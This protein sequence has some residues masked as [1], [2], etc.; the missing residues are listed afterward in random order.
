MVIA[1]AGFQHETNT[2]APSKADYR[3][4]AIGGG[5]PELTE[6][7]AI[8]ERFQGLNIPASGAIATFQAAEK[9]ILPLIWAGATPSAHVTDDAFE[10]ITG[11]MLAGLTEGLEEVE[12]VYLDLHGAMVT[13][14]Y[15]DGEG[16]ILRR[17]R[18]VIGPDVPLVA[19][20]DLHANVTPQMIELA[21]CLVAYLTYPH[22]DMADTG[23]R[24]ATILLNLLDGLTLNK[25]YRQLPFLIP[26][27]SGCSLIEPA[28]SLYQA[29][30]QAD[31]QDAVSLSF[32]AGFGPADI[33][34]CGPSVFA[35]DSDE[36]KAQELCDRFYEAVLAEE[37]AFAGGVLPAETAVRQAIIKSQAA[38]KP[39][40]LADT[41]DNPGAGGNGDTVGLLEELIA[42][43]APNTV[44][45]LLID[46]ETAE[47]AHK[48]GEGARVTLSL[49]AK[50]GIPGHRPLEREMTVLKLG[51]GQ[52]RCDGPFYKGA[53]MQLG[54]MALL[55]VGGIKVAVASKKTQT[56]DQEMFRHLGVDPKECALVVV[57]SSVH[58]RADFQPLSEEVLVAVAPGPNPV[59]HLELDY[60]NLRAGQRIMP[61][62]PV[63][64]G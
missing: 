6:G 32:A 1:V 44:F 63:Q 42:Q 10:R 48:A 22:V 61:L 24:A 43:Q 28:A 5:Y 26:L 4:F 49:G 20:L 64:A 60:K 62:G 35:Y 45:G 54:P 14:S 2:F 12:A 3:A 57:K 56:A 25:A 55:E 29:V 53:S 8:L 40:V 51:D 59:D 52:F 15:E 50:S 30:K 23:V 11:A 37:G 21:D 17:V 33:H 41:Q 38:A 13:E 39:I 31:G 7:A 18:E 47:A 36:T 19:S 34:H 16:E 46:R 27:N 58:F 9:E